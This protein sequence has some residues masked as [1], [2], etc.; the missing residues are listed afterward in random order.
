MEM[1]WQIDGQV[2]LE[3]L[4]SSQSSLTGGRDFGPT[5]RAM[6]GIAEFDQDHGI[7]K[8]QCLVVDDNT[9]NTYALQHVLSLFN[10]QSDTASDGNQAYHWVQ[11]RY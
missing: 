6:K 9:M 1:V 4:E 5:I 7:S 3:S 10:L 2:P 8:A 11:K